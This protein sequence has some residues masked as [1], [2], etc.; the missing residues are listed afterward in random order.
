MTECVNTELQSCPKGIHSQQVFP[1]P[2]AYIK[3]FLA[4]SCIMSGL[5][6][7]SS[8]PRPWE[9]RSANFPG[10]MLSSSAWFSHDLPH[11][12]RSTSPNPWGWQKLPHPKPELGITSNVPVNSQFLQD[13]I[14]SH[15]RSPLQFL[16]AIFPWTWS[17][18]INNSVHTHQQPYTQNKVLTLYFQSLLRTKSFWII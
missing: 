16:V 1:V 13:K 4:Y 2:N 5:G 9:L 17:W 6:S 7:S 10:L 14:G 11:P 15:T 12:H 8:C 18:G 3:S